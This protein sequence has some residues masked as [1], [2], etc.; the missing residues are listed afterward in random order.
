VSWEFP[1]PPVKN[2]ITLLKKYGPLLRLAVGIICLV[3]AVLSFLGVGTQDEP[4]G[5]IIFGL[6]WTCVG[7]L[8]IIRYVMAGGRPT[9]RD[10]DGEE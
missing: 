3:M 1:E 5:R 7:V 10:D 4:N 2:G 8:W 9:P 6:L